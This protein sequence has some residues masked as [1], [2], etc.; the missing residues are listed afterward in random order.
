MLRSQDGF[1]LVEVLTA[2]AITAMVATVVTGV[3]VSNLFGQRRL[4]A[5]TDQN[6]SLRAA[7]ARITLDGRFAFNC[8]NDPDG[9]L[10]CTLYSGDEVRYLFKKWTS[11]GLG[12]D[13]T[14]L[15]RWYFHG[16]TYQNDEI[17]GW[18]LQPPL[19]FEFSSG[20]TKTAPRHF[21][22]YLVKPL[23]PGQDQPTHLQ[24]TVFQRTPS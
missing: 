1:T 19:L 22:V 17:I 7:A 4:L 23:L 18:N 21:T 14:N 6:E 3:L 20:T 2:L 15:H 12:Q 16:G 10:K 11:D 9:N 24:V 5:E 13:D 8:G